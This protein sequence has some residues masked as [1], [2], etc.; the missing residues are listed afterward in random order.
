MQ[1]RTRKKTEAI[2]NHPGWGELDMYDKNSRKIDHFRRYINLYFYNEN[3]LLLFL[4]AAYYVIDCQNASVSMLRKGLNIRFQMAEDLFQDL[5]E[6]GIVGKELGYNKREILWTMQEFEQ[7]LKDIGI[8]ESPEQD[9]PEQD[10]NIYYIDV[11]DMTGE[12]FEEICVQILKNNG[13][14]HV[15]MT[16]TT[17]DRGIDIKAYKNRL[18][19]AIQCKCYAKS[20]GNKAI[21]E[22]HAGREI[23][24]ADKAVVMT[25]SYFTDP[26]KL[27]AKSL[28]VELWDSDYILRNFGVKFS[29]RPRRRKYKRK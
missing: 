16:R 1:L 19:Y 14:D 21:Q 13:F 12:K 24:K 2:R 18:F 29:D 10:Q 27:D 25:N 22:A 8:I 4:E 20:V 28:S 7:A 11:S 5:C 26:A 17:G 3:D 9:P 6:G 15:F 23:Y